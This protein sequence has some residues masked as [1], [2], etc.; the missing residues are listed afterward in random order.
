MP[1]YGNYSLRSEE[2]VPLALAL[3]DQPESDLKATKAEQTAAASGE[4]W[5]VAVTTLQGKCVR[6]NSCVRAAR[7]KVTI[8]QDRTPHLPRHQVRYEHT[9]P[10]IHK[11]S[12]WNCSGKSADS[13]P[14]WRKCSSRESPSLLFS[15]KTTPRNSLGYVFYRSARHCRPAGLDPQE[16]ERL[17]L[18]PHKIPPPCTHKMFL[19]LFSPS[20]LDS[21][22]IFR[23]H[24]S[25]SSN[26]FTLFIF[27]AQP[28]CSVLVV[29][30]IIPDWGEIG[31]V[32]GT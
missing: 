21:T 4:Y 9:S 30:V 12:S 23:A 26:P 1:Y 3:F 11:S 10:L 24:R 15:S 20:G 28:I 19:L 32:S 29:E 6:G 8:S 16:A 17:V 13:S 18:S 25:Q 27:S 2:S 7:R 14:L 5:Q 22:G 31:S